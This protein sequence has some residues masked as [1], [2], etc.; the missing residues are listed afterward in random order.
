MAGKLMMGSGDAKPEIVQGVSF[1]AG[2]A[3][4]RRSMPQTRQGNPLP[5]RE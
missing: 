1:A 3:W 5:K 4:G 2:W